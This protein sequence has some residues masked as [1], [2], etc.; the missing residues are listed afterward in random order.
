MSNFWF[1]CRYLFQPLVFN[2]WHLHMVLLFLIISNVEVSQTETI[3]SSALR[4]R[5]PEKWMSLWLS[6]CQFFLTKAQDG[7]LFAIVGN[8]FVDKLFHFGDCFI[9]NCLLQTKNTVLQNIFMKRSWKFKALQKYNALK[10]FL[11]GTAPPLLSV[12]TT[13]LLNWGIRKVLFL[14]DNS[15]F[16]RFCLLQSW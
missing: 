13:F 10:T 14:K 9:S 12:S 8:D 3:E 11:Y 16:E 7:H 1:K 6:C 5:R 15:F 2:Y 4:R